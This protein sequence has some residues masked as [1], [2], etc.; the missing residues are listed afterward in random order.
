MLSL[1][2][3][4]QIPALLDSL[5]KHPCAVLT[6]EPGAG[7]TTRVPAALARSPQFGGKQVWVLEPRRL[8]AYVAAARVAEEDGSK[9]G[10]FSGYHFR[11]ERAETAATRVLFVTE[12]MFLRRL[13]G[14]PSLEGVGALVLDEFHERSLDADLSL[15]LLRRLRQTRPDLRLLLMSATLDARGIAA[16]LGDAPVFDCPGRTYPIEMRYLEKDRS[17]PNEFVEARVRRGLREIAHEEGDWLVFLPGTGE[18]RRTEA[19]LRGDPL[20]D[21]RVILPLH[22]GLSSQEQR[23][24]L[25]PA[26]KPKIVLATSVA[27]TSL[28]VP[29]V[30]VVVDAGLSRREVF[31]PYSGLAALHSF[32]ANQSSMQQRAGRAGRERPGIALRLCSAA[33][34]QSRPQFEPPEI[35]RS[36]LA[37]AMLQALAAGTPALESLEWLEAPPQPRL[38]GARRVL[39]DLGAL[40]GAGKISA[41]GRRL[42]K[43]PLHPRLAFA[44]L[45]CGA[46]NEA[47]ADALIKALI[48][49]SEERARHL[50]F[51]T[52][53]ARFE[54]QGQSLRLRTQLRD[55][56]K[57]ELKN[58]ATPS[59]PFEE[60][61]ASALLRAFPDQVGFCRKGSDKRGEAKFALATGGEASC[62]D[63]SLRLQ[64]GYYL[65]LE[66]LEQKNVQGQGNAPRVVTL[67]PLSEEALLEAPPRL[68]RE[69]RQLKFDA[70]RQ[71]VEAQVTMRYGTLTLSESPARDPETLAEAGALLAKHAREAGLPAFCPEG[72]PA[73]YL[74]RRAFALSQGPIELPG[75]DELWRYV[76]EAAK[77]GALSF[78]ELRAVDPLARVLEA[79]GPEARKALDSR[80][81]KSVKLGGGRELSINYEEGKEPWIASRLQDF[82]GMR[83]TPRIG[84]KK[85]PLTV[86]LL[87]PNQRA[88][89]ITSDL[90][91]F[92]ER[93]YPR[94][95]SELGRK[96]PRHKW[97]E[98]PL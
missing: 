20:F 69:E 30:R 32:P 12:G 57:D 10:D 29:G 45:A 70:E 42:A 48:L 34:Y 53:L 35:M 89:Q 92:W 6:A 73:R 41:M 66:I 68:M 15:A 50:D 36:D 91:G 96:Y 9:A 79:A 94:I 1:P 22:G 5:A 44:A 24:V 78:S 80:A 26:S 3:D 40:D 65:L 33:E 8:A 84:L 86:Q 90:A 83:E 28:T 31:N 77:A 67:L 82:F 37:Q 93:E 63:D 75:E 72:Q 18:I 49:L 54:P 97:P 60:R 27:E 58:A 19:K 74:A 11:F 56:L 23:A 16:Q 39:G 51:W 17:D 46:A 14:N 71:K 95:R 55:W 47:E 88:L 61:L 21:S 85:T 59:A 38:E 76:E 98:N 43:A 25:G 7:K 64:P 81:P 2:I 4:S 52:A 13:Q 62:R 87:A